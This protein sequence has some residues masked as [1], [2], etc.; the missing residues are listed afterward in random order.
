[1]NKEEARKEYLA[2]RL[3]LS[4]MEHKQLSTQC[5]QQILSRILP[6]C[7]TIHVFLPIADR[8]EPDTLPLIWNIDQLFPE[9]RIAVPVIAAN[10]SLIHV[11]PD[12]PLTLHPG[13]WNIPVPEYTR[14]ILPD[15][16]DCV[17]M[18]MLIFDKEGNR[19]G[20][21]KGYYDAFLP[22][23]RPD[24]IKLGISLFDPVDR[25]D[26]VMHA[27][28]K[29]DACVTPQQLYVFGNKTQEFIN[30]DS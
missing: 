4:A 7:K 15:K 26:D 18:P 22:H 10:G 23:C 27:D 24:C 25:I 9:K 21:G 28:V 16:F 1:M 12:T 20:Y 11:Q 17:L 8:K 2:K 13:R 30:L 5:M 14:E 29:M 6:A 19:V 3:S